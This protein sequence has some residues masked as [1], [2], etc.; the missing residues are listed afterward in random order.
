MT[1]AVIFDMDGVLIDSELIYLEWLTDYLNQREYIVDRKQLEQSIGL[2]SGLTIELMEKIYGKG[3]GRALWEDFLK[4]TACYTLDYNDIL[5]GGIKEL[6]E[7][8][9]KKRVRLA[10]A[11]ASPRDEIEE[12]LKETGLSKWIQVVLSGEEL[13]ESKPNPEIYLAAAEKLDV[14]IKKCIVVEDSKYG[15]EAGKRAGAYVIARKEERFACCQERADK[16]VENIAE[17]RRFLA[18]M[19]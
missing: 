7:Y 11:S 5:F 2:S 18:K 3:T 14:D 12:M 16:I 1:K 17:L 8:L 13:K 15:I 6:V 19:L 10:I 9:A 4:V